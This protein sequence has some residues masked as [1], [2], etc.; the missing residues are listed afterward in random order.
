MVGGASTLNLMNCVAPKGTVVLYS[1]M[2]GQ[3]F[4]GS[5]QKAIFAEVSVRGFWLLHW[6]KTAT[7]AAMGRMYDHL[8][9]LVTSGAL[10]APVAATYGLEQFP[11]AIAQAASFKGKVIFTPNRA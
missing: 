7:D 3:P 1:G 10:T 5:T 8:T 6:H 2:S 4:S 11:D 9:S